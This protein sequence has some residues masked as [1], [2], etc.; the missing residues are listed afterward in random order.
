MV[1]TSLVE[2]ESKDA[3]SADSG[4]LRYNFGLN[5]LTSIQCQYENVDDTCRNCLKKRLKCGAEDKVW[6]TKTEQRFERSSRASGRPLLVAKKRSYSIVHSPATPGDDTLNTMEA[7]YIQF[8]FDIVLPFP[9]EEK[10]RT[11]G[12]RL[13]ECIAH[14]FGPTVNSE[15]VRN[16]AI[17]LS[18]TL[19]ELEGIDSYQ[20]YRYRD[21]LYISIQEA[22]KHKAYDEVVY[23]SYAMCIHGFLTHLPFEEIAIHVRGFL[24]NFRSLKNSSDLSSE[25][26]FLL[27]CMCKDIFCCL[28]GEFSTEDQDFESLP[29]R[30]ES[31]A[32]K[33][34]ELVQL[35]DT[36]FQAEMEFGS[37]PEW[38]PERQVYMR[39]QMLM[40]RLK[41]AFEYLLV[42]QNSCEGEETPNWSE[43]FILTIRSIFTELH[44]I[45]SQNPRLRFL[46][47]RAQLFGHL[48]V[49]SA[50]LP[51]GSQEPEDR[52][53][54]LWQP[55]FVA[56]YNY[57]SQL[58]FSLDTPNTPKN[59]S[60]LEVIET[61]M[62]IC[63][64]INWN[65]NEASKYKMS[66]VSQLRS[67]MLACW[68]EM[69]IRYPEGLSSSTL[70]C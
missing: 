57:E 28:T 9:I 60:P 19:K 4:E 16:A 39:M 48:N 70:E 3:S 6:G 22:L 31:R 44:S 7:T 42:K 27:R 8:Y 23:A 15:S 2:R 45:I 30:T 14:R 12:R 61:G 63:C 52:E 24:H 29:R 66:S 67:L 55:S 10:N 34:F 17:L 54:L 35:T 25:E 64:Q 37:E 26:V 53:W 49:S 21:R 1:T 5:W 47:D 32:K 38:M 50:A 40:F 33:M 43:S 58:L 59:T 62:T 36:L 65:Q 13:A 56:R 68:L 41:F 11:D 51:P 18:Y 69:A 20:I 46:V